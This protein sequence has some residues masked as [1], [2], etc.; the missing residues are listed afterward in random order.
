MKI[1]ERTNEALPS[2]EVRI[3]TFMGI[4]LLLEGPSSFVSRCTACFAS[5]PRAH[6][7][8][9]LGAGRFVP[10]RGPNFFTMN[11]RRIF[12]VQWQVVRVSSVE[13]PITRSVNKAAYIYTRNNSK[14][15]C[16]VMS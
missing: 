6:A 1:K 3:L 5:L 7:I 2:V 16:G 10:G 12:P 4:L 14:C 9:I 15:K 8:E 13:Y 11:S